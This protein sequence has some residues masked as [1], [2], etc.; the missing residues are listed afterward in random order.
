MKTKTVK[1]ETLS[2]TI[3]HREEFLMVKHSNVGKISWEYV[4]ESTH[5]AETVG[6]ATFPIS[7]EVLVVRKYEDGN[8]CSFSL[9]KIQ[10]GIETVI[11]E[12]N[13]DM[14]TLSSEKYEIFFEELESS[15]KS[16]EK[17]GFVRVE[18]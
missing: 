16:F 11:C 18:I 13:A 15:I 3:A 12:D 14:D 2:G 17:R 6:Y 4:W 5:P 10:N 8:R 7:I 1:L 9:S